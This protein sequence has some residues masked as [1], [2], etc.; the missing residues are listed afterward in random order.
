[1]A[2]V[3]AQWQRSCR[4][5]LCCATQLVLE[6]TPIFSLPSKRCWYTLW[7]DANRS[8]HTHISTTMVKYRFEAETIQFRSTKGAYSKRGA[9]H[10]QRKSVRA[11]QTIM[12]INNLFWWRQTQ[13]T[14][15]RANRHHCRRTPNETP[16]YWRSHTKPYYTSFA[17][18]KPKIIDRKCPICRKRT[19]NWILFGGPPAMKDEQ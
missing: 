17:T 15:E 6:L 11:L 13:E 16:W 14:A 9:V 2:F 4:T 3:E 10:A 1:M 7:C 19:S 12:C 5:A 18:H 8:D